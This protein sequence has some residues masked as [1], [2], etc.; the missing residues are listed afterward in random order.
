MLPSGSDEGEGEGEAD[1][2]GTLPFAGDGGAD[3]IG[4]VPM[5][6]RVLDK[7]TNIGSRK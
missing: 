6:D 5:F 2:E 7:V 1:K 3:C 4:S